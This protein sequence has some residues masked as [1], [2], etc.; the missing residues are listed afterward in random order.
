MRFK[1]L[2][3]LLLG[4]AFAL[5]LSIS[6]RSDGNRE[7][8]ASAHHGTAAVASSR[9]FLVFSRFTP[10]VTTTPWIT[11]LT[12]K[13]DAEEGKDRA[14]LMDL[15]ME[16]GIFTSDTRF[17]PPG[18][19]TLTFEGAVI[20]AQVLVDGVVATPGVI[21]WDETMR[22]LENI[23]TVSGL[24]E[25]TDLEFGA[26][27][28][29][30]FKIGLADTPKDDHIVQVQVRFFVDVTRFPAGLMLNNASAEISARSLTVQQARIDL[31]E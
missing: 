25:K 12:T 1:V 18:L 2:R 23:T 31:D 30:F 7:D 16:S 8:Q 19:R 13:I 9:A 10:G 24:L 28:F 15:S 11:V 21:I 27:S 4:L 5:T 6:A 14:L 22:F 3:S 26:R 29:N 20:Q 17:V